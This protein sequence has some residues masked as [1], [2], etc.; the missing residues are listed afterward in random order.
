[1]PLVSW[2]FAGE[3]S[4]ASGMPCFSTPR[5]TWT[6]WIFL[7]PS[8]PRS[9]QLGADLQD[10]L[11][12]TTALGSAVSPQASRQVRRSRSSRRRH[13]QPGPAGKQGEQ[14]V[15]WDVAE[16]SDGTPLHAAEAP[17]R[18]DRL[19]QRRSS[20][21]RLWP[22]ACRLRCSGAWRQESGVLPWFLDLQAART[23]SGRPR[24]S[25]RLRTVTAIRVST[26][27]AG[28][29]CE[30]KVSPMMRLYRLIAPSAPAL[31]L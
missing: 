9:K 1:M 3:T 25:M 15:E 22:G 28:R 10:R 4:I 8:K 16:L 5:W 30:R 31:A 17:D 13:S 12:M 6:P 26:S 20:Q 24:S 23:E 29:V 19:A 14:R 11:S 21:R 27:C 2:T 18:Q 7:P